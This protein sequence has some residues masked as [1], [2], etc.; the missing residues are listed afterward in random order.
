MLILIGLLMISQSD[1]IVWTCYR[2]AHSESADFYGVI[3]CLSK[4][5]DF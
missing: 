5:L 3:V 2:S 4:M 1:A